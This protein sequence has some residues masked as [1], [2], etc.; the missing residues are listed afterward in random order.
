MWM[1]GLNEFLIIT[2]RAIEV[3]Y[4]N[5]RNPTGGVLTVMNP[6]IVQPFPCKYSLNA[7][8]VMTF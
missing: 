6:T 7:V 1:D 5:L 8:L 3:C 4:L 2:C